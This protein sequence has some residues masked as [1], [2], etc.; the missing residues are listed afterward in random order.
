MAKSEDEKPESLPDREASAAKTGASAT[1]KPELTKEQIQE[2]R[3][4]A[5]LTQ[6]ELAEKLDVSTRTVARWE[7]GD[8]KPSEAQTRKIAEMAMML[9]GAGMAAFAARALIAPW[10]GGPLAGIAAMG[11]GAAWFARN[12]AAK[13]PERPIFPDTIRDA[14]LTWAD[15]LDLSPRK[16]RG[17]IAALLASAAETGHSARQLRDLLAHEAE[18]PNAVRATMLAAADG[19]D[20]SP[21]KLRTA[22]FAVLNA[23]GASELS[24]EQLQALLLGAGSGAEG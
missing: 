10:L 23:A 11:A 8:A 7:S 24:D 6:A 4:Q 18:L 2:A 16:L 3:K 1:Q 19:L 12:S 22:L 5:R 15:Q 17:A 14:L 13:V 21:R 9:G 20:L